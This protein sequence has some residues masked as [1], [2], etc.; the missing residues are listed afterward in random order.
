MVDTSTEAVTK[1]LDGVTPGPW[2]AEY[3]DYGEEIWFGGEGCGTWTVGPCFIGGDGHDPDLAR[4]MDAD[5][6]FIAAAR[7][8]V[9]AL[10]TERDALQRENENLRQ[11]ERNVQ[12]VREHEY[13]RA[14]AALAEVE[15]LKAQPAQAV[16]V[17]PLVWE[18]DPEEL[19]EDWFWRAEAGPF[20]YEVG[21]EET[22]VCWWQEDAVTGISICR[23][24]GDIEAAKSAAQAD[25]EARI[26]AALDVQPITVQEA[27]K[28]PEI[29]ALIEAV[30]ALGAMPE[31]YCFCSE[32]RVGDESK[33]H[34]PECRDL[35]A[36]IKS[37]GW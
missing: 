25:Y 19:G 31:G 18:R 5:A 14:E 32:N 26:M 6:R 17:K 7:D 20:V 36:A 15:R 3:D 13:K 4:I 9:P 21:E 16:K 11:I 22:G 27:A 8:L 33:Q 24:D 34:E 28:V 29:A 30:S 2:G 23:A 35:R 1:L 37:F 12:A 10:L